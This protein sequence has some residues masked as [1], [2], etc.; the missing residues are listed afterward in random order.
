MISSSRE[1]VY[2]CKIDD[3]WLARARLSLTTPVFNW[4]LRWARVRS[5]LHFTFH[6]LCIIN[7][8][9]LHRTDYSLLL[10]LHSTIQFLEIFTAPQQQQLIIVAVKSSSVAMKLWCLSQLTAK[11]FSWETLHAAL[12]PHT[13]YVYLSHVDRRRFPCLPMKRRKIAIAIAVSLLC[14]W[15]SFRAK[16][17]HL[18]SMHNILMQSKCKLLSKCY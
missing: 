15:N 4:H 3:R 14:D 11:L 1:S 13:Q 7:S 10:W 5:L 17:V 16:R 12:T 2:E 6:I 8:H 9:V 18:C